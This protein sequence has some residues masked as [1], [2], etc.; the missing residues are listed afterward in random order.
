MV[1]GTWPEEAQ[2]IGIDR[3]G[4]AVALEGFTEML[5]VVPGGIALDEADC[6]KQARAIIN[7]EQQGLFLRSWPPLVDRTVVLPKFAD[8]GAPEAPVA[9]LLGRRR[10]NQA[11]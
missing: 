9:A 2:G 1:A 3:L 7:G 11:G 10:G 4:Q 8:M 6:G 5:E